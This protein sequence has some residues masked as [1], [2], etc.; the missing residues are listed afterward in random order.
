[1]WVR[2][3]FRMLKNEQVWQRGTEQSEERGRGKKTKDLS[4][5]G[6][7]VVTTL[8]LERVNF[9]DTGKLAARKRGTRIAKLL[10]RGKRKKK[11]RSS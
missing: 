5:G 6:N 3:N 11:N 10:A 4:W 2:R 1:M 9:S 7:V 8:G